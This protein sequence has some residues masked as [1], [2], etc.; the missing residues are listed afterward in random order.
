M[1]RLE[2]GLSESTS[3]RVTCADV[4]VASKALEARH[5]CGPAASQALA[6]SLVAAALAAADASSP[7]EAVTL[8]FSV[9]G[10]IGGVLVEARGNGDMRGYTQTKTIDALDGA[11]TY[12]SAAAFGAAGTLHIV[13]SLPGKLLAQASVSLPHPTVQTALA[14]YFNQSLQV[15][16]GVTMAVRVDSGG[17]IQARGLVAER[18]PD[19]RSDAFVQVLEAMESGAVATALRTAGA[20]SDLAAVL[21]LPD[22]AVRES[23]RLQF[24]C[25]CSLP[26][27]LA[28]VKG[29]AVADLDALLDRGEPAVVYC[30]MC[31]N[32]HTLSIELLRHIRAARTA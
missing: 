22:L 30:H 23:R 19:G 31:G 16:A 21:S 14:R 18:M 12:S 4:T 32:G 25:T 13:R 27:V 24:A 17:L 29:L 9:E 26:K 10:P 8:R 2:K 20:L 3:I 11:D 28:V 6:E 15:P 5:L 7:D 1:D